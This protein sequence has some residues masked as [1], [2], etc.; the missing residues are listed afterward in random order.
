MWHSAAE[1]GASGWAAE[2]TN[3]K[4]WFWAVGE[5]LARIECISLAFFSFTVSVSDAHSPFNPHT[6]VN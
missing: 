5:S 1:S 2:R 4:F 6:V 3:C